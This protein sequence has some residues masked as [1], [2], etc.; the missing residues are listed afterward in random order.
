MP[1][2]LSS[3]PSPV[4]TLEEDCKGLVGRAEMWIQGLGGAVR[5]SRARQTK[6]RHKQCME[7]SYVTSDGR[8]CTVDMRIRRFS[9]STRSDFVGLTAAVCSA[10]SLSVQ[11]LRV[12]AS[13]WVLER[14]DILAYAAPDMVALSAGST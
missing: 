12:S 14:Q 1:L 9:V 8:L 5:F 13:R 10:E 11:A 4:A 7:P 2:I 6:N 3:W